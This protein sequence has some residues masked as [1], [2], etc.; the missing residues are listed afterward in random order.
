MSTEDQRAEAIPRM[1]EAPPKT[2]T[3][4]SDP[5]SGDQA[6]EDPNWCGE[7]TDAEDAGV[8]SPDGGDRT[9]YVGDD[10][11]LSARHRTVKDS[12]A[13]AGEGAT[14]AERGERLAG[15]AT[16]SPSSTPPSDGSLFDPDDLAGLRARWGDVQ[17]SFVDDPQLCVQQADGLVSDVVEKLSA[18]FAAARSRLEQQWGQGEAASTEDLRVAL[19]RYREFF[20]RLLAV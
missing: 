16:P 10:P 1:H 2:E 6:A 8:L 7:R 4:W 18:G 19:T 12:T 15:P 9:A 5:K 14:A 20:E 11:Q 3:V 17:A 13:V